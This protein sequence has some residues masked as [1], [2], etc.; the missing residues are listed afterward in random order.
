MAGLLDVMDDPTFRLGMGLL[1]AGSARSDGAGV[2][3][4]LNEVLG[5]MDQWQQ[6][7][8]QKKRAA[9]QEQMFNAQ[10]QEMTQKTARERQLLE[11]EQRKRAGFGE[12][13][14]T[15]LP[16]LM[17]DPSTGILPSAGTGPSIDVARGVQL[18]YTTPELEALAKLRN[19]NL[20]KVART[21]KGMGPDGKEYEYQVDEFGRKVGDGFAQ[22]K[23]PILND[24]GGQTN[25]L[26]PY[27][28][29]KPLGAIPKTMTFGD[30][31]AAGNLALA[32]QR[33]AFDKAGGADA[34]K[35][36]FSAELGGFVFKPDA[37]NPQGKFVPLSGGAGT[38]KLTEDQA[39]ASGWL[40]QAT[41]AFNN[42]KAAVK[43]NPE[44]NKAGVNDAIAG[45]PV[46]GGGVANMLR[47]EDRQKYVQGASSL[48]EALLRAATGAGV[49][50]DE[51]LQKVR[52]L[53]PQIGDS[54]AV[55]TQKEAAIP[56]Y[57]KTLE[58]RAGPGAKQLP[59]IMQPKKL[60]GMNLDPSK[61]DD[62]LGLFK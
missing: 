29:L 45:I 7:Q 55:I 49:N 26:D 14:K 47:G 54:D 23:A 1:G 19:I 3:Q 48:S 11:Q 21:V 57:L 62:P 33:F 25:V 12:V 31:N 46:F 34:V 22:W 24:G 40:V 43:S 61:L 59:N 50:M 18:G 8:A 36:Q 37:A 6:Q 44:A 4:R 58:M 53:T 15:G 32:Q 42:M 2:G 35:P 30:R 27:N 9:L 5:G 16:P 17:G 39:K 20:D 51:A 13:F 38:V 52:E 28:P 41:N 60:P 56:L 10:L